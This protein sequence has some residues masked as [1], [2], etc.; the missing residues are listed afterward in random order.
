MLGDNLSADSGGARNLN[1]FAIWEAKSPAARAQ[2]QT[3]QGALEPALT[4]E[5]LSELL[6][7]F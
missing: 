1:I 6:E 7:F 3:T 4:I 2:H 5:H